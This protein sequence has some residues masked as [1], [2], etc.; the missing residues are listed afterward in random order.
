VVQTQSATSRLG[1][2]LL[3]CAFTVITLGTTLPTPIYA[4]Y[5]QNMHFAV[6]TTTVI[7][8]AYAAGL[9]AG[10]LVFGRW[11]DA[12]GRRPVLIAGAVAAIISAAVFLAAESVPLLFLGRMLSG[13]SAGIFTGTATAAIVESV[14]PDKQATA[15]AGAT[16]ANSCGLGLGPVLAGVLVQYVRDP[17]Q[18][19]YIVHIVMAALAIVA[20]ALVPETSSCIGTIGLQRL[21]VPAKVRPVFI[22]AATAAF[23]GFAVTGLF[24]AVVPSFISNIIGIGNHAVAGAMA[25]SIFAASAAAQLAGQHISPP[26]ALALGCATLT[27]GMVI[28]TVALQYS[29]LA[30]LLLAAVI[31]GTGQGLSFSRGLAAVAEGTPTERRAEVSS[32]YFVVA[33]VAV[34]LPVI[35]LGLAAHRWGLKAS[36]VSFA[37]IV[38]A[39]ALLCLGAIGWQERQ[40]KSSYAASAQGGVSPA[41]WKLNQFRKFP[42]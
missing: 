42:D 25:S 37:V 18:L 33:Y 5:A 40:Q 3:A 35:G 15:A 20:I 16:I 12:I 30:G 23:A 22:T 34:L 19:P 17:L 41:L 31:A 13:L 26:R 1:Y 38:A 14:P 7:F 28:L 8:S 2:P 32:T 39:L 21:S 11:S 27:V 10:L 9:L 6:L 4:L 24:T 29:S 36:G